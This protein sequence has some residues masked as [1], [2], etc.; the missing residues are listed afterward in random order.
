MAHIAL[1]Q[2]N[3]PFSDDLIQADG[4]ALRVAGGRELRH[5]GVEFGWVGPIS[6]EWS[7]NAQATCIDTE[8]NCAVDGPCKANARQMSRRF[9]A[10]LAATWQVP[11]LAG[12]NWTNRVFY[13]D[14]KAITRDNS[15][16][17]PVVLAARQLSGL[18]PK[19]RRRLQMAWR[20]GVDNVT[21]KRYWRD[22]PTQYWGGTYLFPAPPRTFRVSVQASF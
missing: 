4:R 3:K 18:S 6:R 22:A 15:V 17:L 5:Q 20:A 2:I 12:L 8:G 14:K 7:L 21:D 13:S 16:E 10:S 1:F 11:R 19:A 9:T